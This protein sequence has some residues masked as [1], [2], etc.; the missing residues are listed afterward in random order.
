MLGVLV[1]VGSEMDSLCE[2]T[3][4]DGTRLRGRVVRFELVE[5]MLFVNAWI[6]DVCSLTR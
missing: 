6:Y 4:V 3:T 1:R 2:Y 5:G